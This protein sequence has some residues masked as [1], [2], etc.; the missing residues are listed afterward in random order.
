MYKIVIDEAHL[1]PTLTEIPAP[2]TAIILD[3][4][5]R[6]DLSIRILPRSSV[7]NGDLASM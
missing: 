4:P 3:F 1:L 5:Y 2:L 6:R 7:L